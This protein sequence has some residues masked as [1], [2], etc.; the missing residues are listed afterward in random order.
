MLENVIDRRFQRESLLGE[1]NFGRVY[2][3]TDIVL[4]EHVAIK[5]SEQNQLSQ[6]KQEE[7]ILKEMQGTRGFPRFIKSNF[8]EDYNY[9][10]MQLLGPNINEK[11]N[12]C[13][14]KFSLQTIVTLGRQ[15]L[16][17]VKSIHNKGYVHRDLKPHQF[18][19]GP[20]SDRNTIYM[21]DFGLC[22][23]Y[24]TKDLG[25]HI[26]YME[27]RPFV[28]TMYY[29]SLS[30]HNG[31][32]Q[33]RRDDLE[34]LCYIL[35]YFFNGR[36][37]W[38][39]TNKKKTTELKIRTEKAQST[40]SE[41]FSSA[42]REFLELFNYVKSLNFE[43]NPNY[44]YMISLF[45]SIERKN[46]L[47]T[48]PFDWDKPLEMKK[49][50][51]RSKTNKPKDHGLTRKRTDNNIQRGRKTQK[52]KNKSDICRGETQSVLNA[53][54]TTEVIDDPDK[55]IIALGFPEIKNRGIIPDKDSRFFRPCNLDERR[56]QP[57][58]VTSSSSFV[59]ETY[60]SIF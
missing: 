10:A 21:V 34:S 30:T 37:P 51:L 42:P 19:L 38:M 45:E 2:L 47:K 32:Q 31:I 44:S 36:L 5:V 54:P 16:M 24:K 3:C 25:L 15:M 35:S 4:K 22:K 49:T 46:E 57:T 23:R 58:N 29:A 6:I 28:G 8:L 7:T 52:R 40:A 55:T 18:L 59:P 60:C 20:R 56:A 27:N 53:T 39:I 9:I 48:Y 26:A 14:K 33:S 41:L 13:H 43:T 11:F 50:K 1:G 17:R 12:E